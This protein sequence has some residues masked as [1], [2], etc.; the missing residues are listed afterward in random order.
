[1][2]WRERTVVAWGGAFQGECH[3]QL[4]KGNVNLKELFCLPTPVVENV[5][6]VSCLKHSQSQL[7][8][9]MC[10]IVHKCMQSSFYWP[11]NESSG[12]SV[13]NI[14]T[15]IPC[16]QN[17]LCIYTYINKCIYVHTRIFYKYISESIYI[18]YSLGNHPK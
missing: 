11:S 7:N 10:L 5:K 17:T 8:F 2:N 1:M 3:D 18:F 12:V 6:I 4:E 14:F 16:A 15:N 13:D 9:S